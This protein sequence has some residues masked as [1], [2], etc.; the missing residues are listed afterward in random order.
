MRIAHL[1]H[2]DYDGGGR[3]AVRLHQGLNAIGH[4]SL[5]LVAQKKTQTAGIEQVIKEYPARSLT[6]FLQNPARY[7]QY[8]IKKL[9]WRQFNKK[10]Q[11]TSLINFDIPF[12]TQEQLDPY[13]KNADVL[14]LYSVQAFLSAELIAHI[15]KTYQI[16]IFWTLMDIE[17][18]TGGCHFNKGCQ[19]FQTDCDDCPQIA[20]V[21]Q[22]NVIHDIWQRKKNFL[23]LENLHFVPP[24]TWAVDQLQESMLFK[25]Q[26]S[27]KILISVNPEIFQPGDAS[28]ARKKMDVRMDAKVILFGCFNLNDPRKGGAEF[29]QA[30]EHLKILL[31][32]EEA[33][34]VVVLTFGL[35]NGFT[36]SKDVFEWKHLGR[37]TSD[38]DIASAYQ[39]TDVFA[40]P[41]VDDCGP[42]MINEAMMCA[43]P[44]V[45]FNNGVAPDFI[46]SDQL[47]YKAKKFDPKDFGF[48]L[49]QTL[50]DTSRSVED[51]DEVRSEIT[52][53]QCARNYCQ[54]FEEILS[55]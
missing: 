53:E 25:K 10:C 48:G 55:S 46:R 23:S 45:A 6:S 36:I 3:S 8:V 22:K 54:F 34:Q 44:T 2:N 30:L 16:P 32:A 28:E 1:T 40:C 49:K 41:S 52:P 47:G 4:E 18:I 39:A 21:E 42:M 17:P 37:L 31:T 13:L 29:Q 33:E 12:V 7:V 14:C 19:Q 9:R 5:M 38:K 35:L 26:K 15:A 11:P 20:N 24:T 27:K 43:R 51:F 50:F